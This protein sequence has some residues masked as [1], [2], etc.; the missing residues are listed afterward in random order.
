MPILTSQNFATSEKIT[1]ITLKAA[2]RRTEVAMIEPNY[3]H[4]NARKNLI[5]FVNSLKKSLNFEQNQ[6]MDVTFL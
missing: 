4:A 5:F 2:V 6:K 3:Y 1:E